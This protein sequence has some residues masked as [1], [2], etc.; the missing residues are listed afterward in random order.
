MANI[1]D[2]LDWRGDL[3]FS[4]SPFNEIDNLILSQL[5][6]VDFIGI[7]PGPD[8]EAE[9][10]VKDAV[11]FYFDIHDEKELQADKSFIK[12]IPFLLK[13]A[14]Q[15]KRFGELLLSRYVNI[16]DEE[17]EEQFSA[18]HVRIDKNL[19]YVAFRGTD[20]TL[21]G[22]KEDFNLG[23]IMPIPSQVDA[24]R[25][26][27]STVKKGSGKLILGG[28]SKGG[29]LAIYAAV[30]AKASVKKKI[31]TVYNNDGPGFDEKFIKSEKY[32]ESLP[33]IIG[34][35]PKHSIVGM[36]LNHDED[37]MIV[38]SSQNGIMQHDAMS[39]QVKGNTFV[40]ASRLDEQ[41]RKL[42]IAL[43]RWINSISYKEREEFINA[44]FGILSKSGVKNLSQIS[45]AGFKG[46]STVIANF[47]SLKRSEKVMIYKLFKALSGEVSKALRD[48]SN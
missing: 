12:D 38:E 7:V 40:T 26:V 41:S 13:K 18:F 1:M 14:A 22:W 10:A 47:H 3:S 44:L 36:L 23:F 6:Y 19:T 45:S 17:K 2:Y 5:A 15:T 35:V 39:W 46:M 31:I 20:D 28:H 37:Y 27:N 4:A 29:N 25:Y 34:I 33:K 42:N 16:V 32:M 9:I 43:S 30:L 48:E 21:I 11:Q 8:E 24:L